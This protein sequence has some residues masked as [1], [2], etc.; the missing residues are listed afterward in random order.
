MFFKCKWPIHVL[1]LQF[2]PS[3]KVLMFKGKKYVRKDLKDWL[4]WPEDHCKSGSALTLAVIYLVL[5]DVKEFLLCCDLIYIFKWWSL[6]I[7][8]CDTRYAVYWLTYVALV[9]NSCK[10]KKSNKT[11][12][13]P[14]S[15]WYHL[16]YIYDS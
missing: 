8:A 16:K 6:C 10:R 13:I 7:Q 14:K 5:F 9:K 12:M 11:L 2:E 15:C 4:Y 3:K 1:S